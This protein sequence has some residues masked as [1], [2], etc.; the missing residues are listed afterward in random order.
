VFV[1]LFSQAAEMQILAAEWTKLFE[2][3]PLCQEYCAG[4]ASRPINV[5]YRPDPLHDGATRIGVVV[6]VQA[7]YETLA[8]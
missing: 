2:A 1:R 3:Q 8:N 5:A 7:H 6:A 4:C